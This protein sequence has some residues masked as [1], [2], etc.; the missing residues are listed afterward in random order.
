MRPSLRAPASWCF[1]VATAALLAGAQQPRYAARQIDDV[2]HLQD[3]T[4][5]TTVSVIPSVGNVAFDMRVKGEPILRFPYASV[6]EFKKAP[7]LSGI[8]FLAPWANRL[9]EQGFY[10]NGKHYT[11]NTDL[12]T[13]RGP[14]PIH[15]LLASAAGWQVVEVKSDAAAA[16]VTSKL[17]FFRQPAW[18]AQFPFAHTIEMTY[19][20]SDGTL[21]VATRITNLS[22]EPMPVAIGFHPYFQLTDSPRDEWTV[23]IGARTQWLL[24]SDKI[25]TGETRPIAFP[26]PGQI[27]LR[28]VNLD[29]V[30]GDLVRDA[31][32]RAVMSVKG[33][34]QRLD[35]LFGPRYRAAVIYS[36]PPGGGG[37]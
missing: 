35:V 14:H 24:S 33:R 34:S 37:G 12:G 5:Q 11:F 32:G 25:P 4:S 3:T 26:N 18:M 9:D 30:F 6:E 17:E 8:P 2:V 10:A 22:A 15:G 1:V 16:W 28:D 20:L 19:R 21:E 7:R 29:D 36:P 31:A 13:V 27:A 23:S